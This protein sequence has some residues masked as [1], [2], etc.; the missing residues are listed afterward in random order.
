MRQLPLSNQPFDYDCY[1]QKC[2]LELQFHLMYW[3]CPKDPGPHVSPPGAVSP[4]PRIATAGLVSS[5]TPPSPALLAHGR[6]QAGPTAHPRLLLSPGMYL[7]PRAGAVPSCLPQVSGPQ[8]IAPPTPILREQPFLQCPDMYFLNCLLNCLY[9]GLGFPFALVQEIACI[10]KAFHFH[11]S[12]C[13]H[14]VT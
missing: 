9:S 8:G 13:V 6:H 10:L 12:S 7:M 5:S 4:S 11:R 14:V 2:L 1:H 3:Q